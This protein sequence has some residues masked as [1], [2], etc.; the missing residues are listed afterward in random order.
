M[1]ISTYLHINIFILNQRHGYLF[2]LGHVKVC[3]FKLPLSFLLGLMSH[4]EIC[5]LSSRYFGVF[6]YFSDID[7]CLIL[8]WSENIFS[9]I[10]TLSTY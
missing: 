5:G 4:S 9:M 6:R 3:N 8:L 1:Q 10:S 7:F 2:V